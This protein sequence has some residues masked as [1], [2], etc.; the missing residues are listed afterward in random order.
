MVSIAKRRSSRSSKVTTME[1]DVAVSCR[2]CGAMTDRSDRD[3]PTPGAGTKSQFQTRLAV[4]E[5]GSRRKHVD[6]L[7]LQNR[8]HTN[9][10]GE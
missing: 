4:E 3:P 1:A 2:G 8:R 6:I 10:N 9:L 7:V 5:V